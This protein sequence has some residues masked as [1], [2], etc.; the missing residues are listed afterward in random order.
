MVRTTLKSANSTRPRKAAPKRAPLTTRQRFAHNAARAQKQASID[1]SITEW[2]QAMLA[3]AEE[4]AERHGKKPRYFLDH[5]FHGGA[6]MAFKRP[7]VSAWN[8]WSSKMAENRNSGT[9]NLL[10]GVAVSNDYF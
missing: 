2:F 5:F 10:I 4:L 7:K 1:S 3:T 9:C 6:C 8:A